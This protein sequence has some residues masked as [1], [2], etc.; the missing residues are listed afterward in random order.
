MIDRASISVWWQ[1]EMVR[2]YT[3]LECGLFGALF[4]TVAIT[5]VIIL[6]SIVA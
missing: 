5:F 3:K 2:E 6:R 1:N 4:A